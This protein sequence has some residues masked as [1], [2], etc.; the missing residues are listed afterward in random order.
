VRRGWTNGDCR[1]KAF[2]HPRLF[3]AV[4]ALCSNV[5]QTYGQEFIDTRFPHQILSIN[6]TIEEFH[7][8]C[9]PSLAVVTFL[10]KK[11]CVHACLGEKLAKANTLLEQQGFTQA[12]QLGVQQVTGFRYGQTSL[13]GQGLAIDIDAATNPYLIHERNETKL[14]EALAVV[15]ERIAQLM[16]GRASMIPH[17]GEGH[18]SK[19][20]RHTYVTRIYDTLALENVA[21][22][23]YFALMQDGRELRE[24]VSTPLG[25]Q[26]VRL[27]STFLSVL[28]RGAAISTSVSNRLVDEIRLCM[29][30]DWV[31]LT[32]RVGPAI[33][34][35]PEAEG[36]RPEKKIPLYY[37]AGVPP[38]SDTPAKGETDGPFG[39]K[40]KVYP[41]RSPLRGFLTFRKELV[42]ALI[43]SGLRWGAIDFGR[44]SGDL[45]HFDS[46]DT[47]CSRAS[48][49]QSFDQFFSS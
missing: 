6:K 7:V 35:L 37:L 30:S 34:A 25:S 16:L 26:R 23:R 27:P 10:H 43:D 20:E 12:S 11:I 18:Q 1:K 45:M 46:R 15:Y 44:A 5:M 4:M 47:I 3:L 29:M 9:P 40:D 31:T 33:F 39:S 48:D 41:G 17:L 14:D 32:G 24:Y 21:M 42:L 8:D 28:S 36:V 38:E 19:E 49:G 2:V 13:H 22:Q